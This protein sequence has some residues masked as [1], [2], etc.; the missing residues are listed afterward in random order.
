MLA[1][2]KPSIVLDKSYLDG[3]PAN[4]VRALCD[5]YAALMP[6]ELFYELITTRPESQKRCFSKLPDRFNPVLLVPSIGTLLRAE[7]EHQVACSPIEAHIVNEDFEFN[8]KLREGTYVLEGDVL[9]NLAEWRASVAQDT[10]GFIQRWAVVHHFFPEL[11]EI[12][13]KDFPEAIQS[14]RQKVATDND[15]VRDI[16][17]SFLD[18]DAPKDAPSPESIA[19]EWVFF[20]WVQCQV[21]ASLRLFGRYQGT[22]PNSQGQAFVERIEHSMLDSYYLIYG[23][24]VGRI[25]TLDEEVRE[26]FLSLLPNGDLVPPKTC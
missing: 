2:M 11:N 24:L 25:A 26:D 18:E 1:P 20:R 5:D 10:K 8:R 3:A 6:E 23:S 13:W 9:R 7:M 4:E 12:E 15:F 16:Y 17:A 19:P 21:L 22:V 14:A